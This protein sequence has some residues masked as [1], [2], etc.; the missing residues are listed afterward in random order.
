MTRSDTHVTVIKDSTYKLIICSENHVETLLQEAAYAFRILSFLGAPPGF[1]I[2]WWRIPKPRLLKPNMFPTRAEV[3]GGWAYRGQPAVWVYRLEEWDR[4]LIHEC[5]HALDWD[6]TI[7]NHLKS[8]LETSQNGSLMDALFEAATELTAEWFWCIINAPEGDT[9]G[10]TWVQQKHWQQSQAYSILARHPK[11]NSW[12]EDTSIFAYYILKTALAFEDTTFFLNWYAGVE[13]PGRW[14][15]LW[16]KY[17]EA[18]YH[19]AQMYKHTVNRE[20]SMR[21][22]NPELQN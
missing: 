12:S 19:K 20:I 13:D 7:P 6:V 18:F 16:N 21:M 5:V 9:T 22:T 2:T 11:N 15:E 3:N 1:T 4:V 10:E 8:C 17:K 14:C